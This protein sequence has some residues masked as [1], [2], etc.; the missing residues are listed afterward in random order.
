[1]KKTRPLSSTL[2]GIALAVSTLA[3]CS[4]PAP[5]MGDDEGSG[6]DEGGGK[7]G[8]VAGGSGGKA[9]GGSGGKAAGGSGGKAADGGSG[10]TASGGT[11]GGDGGTAGGGS[12]MGGSGMGGSGDPD[13][14]TGT[15]PERGEVGPAGFPGWKYSKSIKLDTT[16]A[17]ANVMGDVANYPIAVVLSAANFDFAQAKAAGEDLRFGKADG[18]PLP[19]AIESW[20]KAGQSAAVWVKVEKVTGN[21]AADSINMYWGKDDAGDASD[22]KSVF[23][24]ADGFNGVW[25]LA[26][27][28][29][30]AANGYKDATANEAHAQG[31]NLDATSRAP[32][33]IG[34][35][36]K[37]S[38]PK[39]QWIKVEGEKMG[40]FDSLNGM[41]A[42]IWGKADAFLAKSGPGGYDTI[43]S[44]GEGWTIQRLGGGPKMEACYEAGGA[45][46]AISGASTTTGVWY[47]LTLVGAGGK[48]KFYINGKLE[49]QSGATAKPRLKALAI[50]NQSQYIGN[51]R[52]KRSWDGLLDE[53]RFMKVAKDD[54]WIKL[55]Y[56]SQ[57][58]GSKFLSFGATMTR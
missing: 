11:S 36:A 16:A 40:L 5:N 17:G 31:V 35:G 19:Y 2:A 43:F 3:S 49:G 53:P 14:G 51:P 13:A 15:L 32:A 4:A 28:P 7:G 39:E 10:G 24:V 57:K 21:S 25:H 55:E 38:N 26:D 1:M 33:R 52:E 27:E 12:G 41:T 18:T 46:C 20:D 48:S 44:K 23:S 56:E 8:K 47:H 54:N 37:V 58:E 30:V 34:L 42:S 45:G 50:G 6:G 22:S 29:G 9:A